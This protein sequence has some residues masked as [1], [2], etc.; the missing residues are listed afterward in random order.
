MRRVVGGISQMAFASSCSRHDSDI[1][2]RAVRVAIFHFDNG[3][4]QFA[5][6]VESTPEKG[7][8]MLWNRLS[9]G[10][11]KVPVSEETSVAIEE[12]ASAPG[13]INPV[14]QIGRSV[15]GSESLLPN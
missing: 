1:T 10:T 12:E 11:E 6:A 4:F 2:L 9:V 7:S 8:N 14:G 15:H 13:D 5:R 3:I